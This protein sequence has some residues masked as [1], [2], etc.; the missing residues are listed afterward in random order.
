[1]RTLAPASNIATSSKM[2]EHFPSG[3][4]QQQ[5]NL[6]DW[7]KVLEAGLK[8]RTHFFHTTAGSAQRKDNHIWTF[9]G[10]HPSQQI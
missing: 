6:D 2:T 9:C 5:M 8:D 1:M 4:K 7:Y 10:G 3:T